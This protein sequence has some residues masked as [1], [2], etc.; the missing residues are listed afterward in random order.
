MMIKAKKNKKKWK[1]SNVE[2][3]PLFIQR[4]NQNSPDTLRYASLSISS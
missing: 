1:M 2:M 3:R 4:K